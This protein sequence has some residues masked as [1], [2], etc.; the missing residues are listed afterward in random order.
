MVNSRTKVFALEDRLLSL[1]EIQYVTSFKIE[2][3]YVTSSRH[4]TVVLLLVPV[5]VAP[6]HTLVAIA[7]YARH[8]SLG[9]LTSS[10]EF[11]E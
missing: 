2:I 9:P 11:F 6:N 10:Y 8:A 5:A 4:N 3:H 1:I 7:P